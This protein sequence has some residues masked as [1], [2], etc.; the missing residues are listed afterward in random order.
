M[1]KQTKFWLAMTILLIIVATE[2]VGFY[3][4]AQALDSLDFP[5]IEEAYVNYSKNRQQTETE[6]E[7][8]TKSTKELLDEEN[9]RLKEILGEHND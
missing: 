3:Y 1:S 6:T 8:E 2:V 9:E 4:L 5:T 7:E